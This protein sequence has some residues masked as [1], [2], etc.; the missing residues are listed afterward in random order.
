MANEIN[1]YSSMC[2]CR[3]KC[4]CLTTNTY[5][6]CTYAGADISAKIIPLDRKFAEILRVF[7]WFVQVTIAVSFAFTNVCQD[8]ANANI[9][10][11]F[12]NKLFAYAVFHQTEAKYFTCHIFG[13]TFFW[14][15]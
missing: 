8:L 13:K 9:K 15:E 3:N 2:C 6:Q 14:N 10:L 7:L 4:N 1:G 11:M 5:V 12:L